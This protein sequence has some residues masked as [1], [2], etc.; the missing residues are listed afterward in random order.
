MRSE[1]RASEE[2]DG[3]VGDVG[4]AARE[5]C[6]DML[7]GRRP[8]GPSAGPKHVVASILERS[9]ILHRVE[10]RVIHHQ[11]GDDR[12]MIVLGKKVAWTE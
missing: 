6:S 10:M 7:P 2:D 4:H 11:A 12:A 8:S 1:S 5:G 3:E 9:G